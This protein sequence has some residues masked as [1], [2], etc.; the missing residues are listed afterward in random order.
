MS[1]ILSHPFRLLP[2]GTIATVEQQSDTA[3]AE[4]IAVLVLTRLRERTLVPGFGIPDPAFRGVSSSAVAAGISHFGPPVNLVAIT[5]KN[6]TDGE[7]AVKIEF[8]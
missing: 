5:A 1:A 7:Q 2:N 6:L 3:D 4:Q 8:A